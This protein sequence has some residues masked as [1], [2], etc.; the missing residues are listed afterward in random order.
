MAINRRIMPDA[1][2][3]QS[4]NL[5]KRKVEFSDSIIAQTQTS[6]GDFSLD[7]P[8]SYAESTLIGRPKT[9]A[10]NVDQT[11]SQ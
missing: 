7:R 3:Y 6:V 9:A 10:S 2:P 8:A 1:Y 4:S 5:N 11:S